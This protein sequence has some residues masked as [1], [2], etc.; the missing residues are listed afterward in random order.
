MYSRKYGDLRELKPQ[1]KKNGYLQVGLHDKNNHKYVNIHRLVAEAFI[2][3]PDNLPEVNHK[4]EDKTNNHVN[5][6]EWCTGSYNA[7][8][9]SRLNRIANTI[10]CDQKFLRKDNTTG[11]KG[12]FRNSK[13]NTYWVK[14][15]G[16]Y[17]GSFKTFED[18][19]QAREKAECEYEKY[20]VIQDQ[21]YI[22]S[23]DEFYNK[24][25]EENNIEV[26]PIPGACAMVNA[27]ICSG[28]DTKEFSFLGF[29]PNRL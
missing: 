21:K 1:L 24:Y 27:L 4:D 22:S 23:M 16:K 5:N 20:R 18:A 3:N 19:V 28:L 8:Y 25:L 13:A 12:V 14:L 11:R 9:G 15:A 6:L 10:C 29:L 26:I 2:P 7:R 17:I